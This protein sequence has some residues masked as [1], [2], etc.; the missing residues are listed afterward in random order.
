MMSAPKP[1][2][3]LV[4]VIDDDEDIVG[5]YQAL[6]ESEGYR[7][8]VA[9]NGADGLLLAHKECPDLILLDLMLPGIGG[10]ELNVILAQDPLTAHI[11]LIIVSAVS[12]QF[13]QAQGLAFGA[14]DYVVKPFQI[15][16]LL[17][18]IRAALAAPRQPCADEPGEE[19]PS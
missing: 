10:L 15:D 3:E 17:I 1:T 16:D 12:D 4:L 8:V 2:P 9:Y 11:P 14:T 13:R 5:V 19:T 6:L 18:R 7:V